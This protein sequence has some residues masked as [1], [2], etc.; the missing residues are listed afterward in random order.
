MV[1]SHRFVAAVLKCIDLKQGSCPAVN[2]TPARSQYVS[3]IVPNT[4]R[5]RHLLNV[6][7]VIVLFNGC[8]RLRSLHVIG[9]KF[10]HTLHIAT[11]SFPLLRYRE[12]METPC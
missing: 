5:T 7:E 2:M 8:T 11:H 10:L 6:D 4:G 3:T 1:L 12:S 9:E